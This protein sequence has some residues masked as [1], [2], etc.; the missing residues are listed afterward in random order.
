MQPSLSTVVATA[1]ASSA[2]GPGG[3]GLPW[4]GILLATVVVLVAITALARRTRRRYERT[5]HLVDENGQPIDPAQV[6]DEA[7]LVHVADRAIRVA[8]D[9]LLSSSDELDAL[10]RDAQADHDALPSWRSALTDL[11]TQ[12][13]DVLARRADLDTTA[14]A[15][16][17]RAV[18]TALLA[19]AEAVDARLDELAP[20]VEAA[21]ALDGRAD[22]LL[23]EAFARLDEL[24]DV[25]GPH[26]HALREA[27][28]AAVVRAR[29]S[30]ELRDRVA[31]LHVVQAVVRRLDALVDGPG[32]TDRSVAD[33]RGAA[34]TV[35]RALQAAGRID[36][37][38]EQL[39][40]DLDAWDRPDDGGIEGLWVLALHGLVTSAPDQHR[41]A[42]VLGGSTHGSGA[43]APY[44]GA[45]TPDRYVA[46][47]FGGRR[48]IDR[49]PTMTR[50]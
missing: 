30:G 5:H 6:L 26:V 40:A 16:E 47:G 8:D 25:T 10:E 39:D 12:V 3:T 2:P 19:T 36:E 49:R 50:L 18:A 48:S 23:D 29:A 27:A 7:T 21:R 9:V 14:S 44:L 4:V 43:N 41:V 13:D 45:E 31:E 33:H 20:A 22:W 1:A 24:S 32:T 38:Q 17:R 34:S 11:R 46:S 42:S 37:A 35:A 15:R 28:Q